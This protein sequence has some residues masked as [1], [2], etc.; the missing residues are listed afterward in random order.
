MLLF[1]TLKSE[2]RVQMWVILEKLIVETAEAQLEA[3]W[4]PRLI[5][6]GLISRLGFGQISTTK[7]K[8]VI[9]FSIQPL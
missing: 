8:T 1:C 4:T 6:V 3:S 2:A 7:T 5:H 9:L